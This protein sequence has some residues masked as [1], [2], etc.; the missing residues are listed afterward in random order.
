MTNIERTSGRK[1]VG[2]ATKRKNREEL[3]RDKGMTSTS[4]L[5]VA[6][7][8]QNRCRHQTEEKI[9]FLNQHEVTKGFIYDHT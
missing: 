4:C 8:E 1:Y 6:P 2:K 5:R 9:K 3:T 7:S